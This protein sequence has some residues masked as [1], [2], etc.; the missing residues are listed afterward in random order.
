MCLDRCVEEQ[1]IEGLQDFPCPDE[2]T[3][4]TPHQ[5]EQNRNNADQAK[6]PDQPFE[7]SFKDAVAWHG[8][9]SDVPTV[10]RGMGELV[11]QVS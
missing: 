7:A 10:N 1:F 2:K 3:S 9:E 4:N 6:T 11:L 8:V 5:T